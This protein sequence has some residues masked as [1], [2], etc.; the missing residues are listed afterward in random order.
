MILRGWVILYTPPCALQPRPPPGH[1]KSDR[2]KMGV[3]QNFTFA[4]PSGA[5]CTRAKWGASPQKITQS[6]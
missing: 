2:V 1:H 6:Q 5:R 4:H 3:L